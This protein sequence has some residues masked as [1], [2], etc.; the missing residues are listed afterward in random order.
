MERRASQLT[1]GPGDCVL[2]SLT[3][4]S[5]RLLRAPSLVSSVDDAFEDDVRELVVFPSVQRRR[6]DVD[7]AEPRVGRR[8]NP[9]SHEFRR[10]IICMCGV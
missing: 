2:L 4:F 5:F 7:T 1:S 10:A 6:R 3:L 8:P 9:D